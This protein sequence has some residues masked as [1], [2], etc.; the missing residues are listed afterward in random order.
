MK[1]K[2]CFE[3]ALF[4]KVRYNFCKQ[5]KHQT[6]AKSTISH[7]KW[8]K[9][10]FETYQ[11]TC[12]LSDK[13]CPSHYHRPIKSGFKCFSGREGPPGGQTGTISSITSQNVGN[14]CNYKA[15]ADTSNTETCF[16]WKASGIKQ[17]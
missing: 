15:N 1:N 9:D 6:I 11:Y 8:H 7:K 12:N 17:S 4:P 5:W 10:E 13:I 2:K 3:A 14:N 16:F